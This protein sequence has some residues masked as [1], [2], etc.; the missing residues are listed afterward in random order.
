MVTLTAEQGRGLG[1]FVRFVYGGILN[2]VAFIS[3][4]GVH[5][6][7][8]LAVRCV[9]TGRL[10]FCRSGLS[11]PDSYYITL[12]FVFCLLTYYTK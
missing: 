9:T 11:P 1:V 7:T 10:L 12:I 3:V 6:L 8:P 2:A 4:V 5:C